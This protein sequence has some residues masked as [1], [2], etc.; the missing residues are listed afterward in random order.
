MLSEKNRY[1]N[2]LTDIIYLMVIAALVYQ[3]YVLFGQMIVDHKGGPY[4]SDLPY[5]FNKAMDPETGNHRLPLV[6]FKYLYSLTRCVTTSN[7]K[8]KLSRGISAE[9]ADTAWQHARWVS[10]S[11]SAQECLSC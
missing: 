9:A 11:T 7:L 4:W 10:P 8:R 6:L 3:C 5:Y 1:K 2:I